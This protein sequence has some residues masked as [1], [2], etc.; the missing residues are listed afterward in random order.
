M[1]RECLYALQGMNGDQARFRIQDEFYSKL[2]NMSCQDPALVASS[3][4]G[5][6]AQDA[7]QLRGQAGWYDPRIQNF[8]D[9]SQNSIAPAWAEAMSMY[10]N[11]IHHSLLADLEAQL[12]QES[13]ELTLRRLLVRL[14]DPIAQLRTLALLIDG[15]GALVGG[16]LLTALH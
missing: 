3:K 11:Q 14:L 2:P 4:L 10:L 5:N 6:G 16:Q 12:Q 9:S 15:V 7:M 1:L 13:S 8:I